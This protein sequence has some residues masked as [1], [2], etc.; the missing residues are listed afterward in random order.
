MLGIPVVLIYLGFTGDEG[1]RADAGVPFVDAADWRAA[2]SG[3]TRD[4][5]PLDLLDR[6]IDLGP[7]PAWLTLQS[8]AVMEVSA[9]RYRA[10]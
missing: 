8:R 3:Y 4:I 2:F 10:D 7:A 6:R 9:P 1:I 5:I